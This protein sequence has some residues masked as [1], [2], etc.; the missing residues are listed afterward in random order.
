MIIKNQ[1]HPP[2]KKYTD[3]QNNKKRLWL[4]DGT[5][6]MLFCEGLTT[7]GC[8]AL[9]NS[10]NTTMIKLGLKAFPNNKF[11]ITQ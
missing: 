9:I 10:L 11:L 3:A 5:T 4:K 2:R 7:N 1:T 6:T 8:K